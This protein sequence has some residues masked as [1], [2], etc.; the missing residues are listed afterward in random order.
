MGGDREN[1]GDPALPNV[2]FKA[3]APLS[4]GQKLLA[5]LELFPPAHVLTMLQRTVLTENQE[6]MI[7]ADA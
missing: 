6:Q 2:I 3:F 7:R 4:T 5:H 1:L